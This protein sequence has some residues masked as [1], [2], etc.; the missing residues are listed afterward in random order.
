MAALLEAARQRSQRVEVPGSRKTKCA[1]SCHA[2]LC[3]WNSEAGLTEFAF[4][5]N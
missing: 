2:S 3:Y 5:P 1:N 4:V